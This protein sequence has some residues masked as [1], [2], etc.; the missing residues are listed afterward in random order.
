MNIR[1]H[2]FR[3]FSLAALIVFTLT[4]AGQTNKGEDLKTKDQYLSQSKKQKT[5]GW[6]SLGIGGALF[7]AGA[8]IDRDELTQNGVIYDEYKND[9]K[10]DMFKG[11]GFS[12]MVGGAI[13]VVLGRINKRKASAITFKSNQVRFIHSSQV[14][15]TMQAGLSVT[16]SL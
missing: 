15:T 12:S 11:I 10:K 2:L 13:L 3:V 9:Q 5:V 8:A 7:A 16:I 14:V 4:T 6:I 1:T